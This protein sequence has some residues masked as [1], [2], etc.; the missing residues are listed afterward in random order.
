IATSS[1]HAYEQRPSLTEL[2]ETSPA[3]SGKGAAY[4]QSKR[5]MQQV[6]LAANDAMEVLVANPTGVIGPPDPRPSLMGKAIIDISMGRIPAIFDGGF[7]FVDVR[8]VVQG[9]VSLMDKGVPGQNYLLS[10]RY[11]S[12]HEFIAEIGEA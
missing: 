8:D 3:V 9:L 11:Y 7:D 4:D 10:G 12:I 2:N 6:L 1:I 5:E